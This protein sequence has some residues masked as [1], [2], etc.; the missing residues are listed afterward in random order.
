MEMLEKFYAIISIIR[1][2][3][4]ENFLIGSI[5]KG[6]DEEVESLDQVS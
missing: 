5:K 4:R 2:K 1:W 3:F 6:L